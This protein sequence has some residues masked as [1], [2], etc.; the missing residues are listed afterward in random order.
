MHSKLDQI[1]EYNEEKPLDPEE[2]VKLLY[3]NQSNL[4]IKQTKK[5]T[6][7]LLTKEVRH[8]INV[9]KNKFTENEHL[10]EFQVTSSSSWIIGK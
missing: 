2:N 5:F 7:K 9:I 6:N 8:Y 10:L 1:V 3:Y 4:A